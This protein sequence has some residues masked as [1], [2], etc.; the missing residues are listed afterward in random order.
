MNSSQSITTLDNGNQLIME[1]KYMTT[2]NAVHQ[3]D[4]PQGVDWDNLPDVQNY[5][6]AKGAETN[7]QKVGVKGVEIPIRYRA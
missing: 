5:L 3:S 6:I 2:K 1:S 7:I 4:L